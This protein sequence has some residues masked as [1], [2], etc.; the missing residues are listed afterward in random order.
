MKNIRKIYIHVI[1]LVYIYSHFFNKKFDSLSF[2]LGFGYLMDSKTREL[3]VE[4]GFKDKNPFRFS[5]IFITGMLPERLNFICD[6]LPFTYHQ[7]NADQ[8]INIIKTYNRKKVHE[9][10]APMIV[11]STGRHI[12]QNTF[13]DYYR[14]WTV[15]KYIYNDR[16]HSERSKNSEN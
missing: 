14:I 8:C 10:V 11:C 2:I 15:L 7:G 13:S 9:S 1:V 6:L 3:L 5:D 16:I 12:A 4:E